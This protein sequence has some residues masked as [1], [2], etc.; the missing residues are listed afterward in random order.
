MIWILEVYPNSD[1]A[2][3]RTELQIIGGEDAVN[4]LYAEAR[5][6]KIEWISPVTN[7]ESVW[8]WNEWQVVGTPNSFGSADSPEAGRLFQPTTPYW[9][10]NVVNYG[11]FTTEPAQT[12]GD[13]NERLIA[14]GEKIV[15]HHPGDEA[16][17]CPP[18]GW[19]WP[20]LG[21]R[22]GSTTASQD[23]QLNIT[24]EV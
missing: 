16:L 13:F 5:V 4:G 17:V 2:L 8:V 12:G 9:E 10:P 18:P 11:W 6:R 7:T 3:N 1:T 20:V 19:G 23:L 22:I 21:F 14:P 15:F 24:I